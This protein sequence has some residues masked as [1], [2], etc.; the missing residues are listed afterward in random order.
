MQVRE[1]IEKRRAYRALAP[2]EITDAMVKEL[3][4]AASMAPSCF[5]NQPWRLIFIRQ[6]D[7]LEKMHA[8]LSEGNEWARD[9]SML[10]IVASKKELDCIIRDREYY[11]FDTGLAIGQLMLLATEMG[12]VAHAMAGFSPK[13][14]REILG[15][16]GDVG[17]IT[18][19]GVGA[20]SAERTVNMT[21]DDWEAE[22]IRPQ[23]L[24]F[25]D[26]AFMERYS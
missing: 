11:L 21:D 12:L 26:F 25:P 4:W 3:A 2:V 10:I 9:A 20:K 16:P 13:K 5:N 14:T 19:I 1:A 23:R 18:V 15:I 8:A 7:M 6:K 22:D 17:V 24:E